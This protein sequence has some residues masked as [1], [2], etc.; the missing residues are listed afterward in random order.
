LP[1]PGQINP[2][3]AVTVN[4]DGLYD[5]NNFNQTDASLTI[6]TGTAQTGTGALT[7]TGALIIDDGA[8]DVQTSG[9]SVTANGLVTMTGGSIN[10]ASGGTLNLNNDLVASSDAT[11]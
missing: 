6:N 7:V 1:A 4:S 5:L 8:L 3:S 2:A 9:G 10:L 11:G